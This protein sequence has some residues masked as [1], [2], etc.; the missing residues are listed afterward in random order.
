LG[1]IAPT[2]RMAP[3]GGLMMAL[4][5]Y[6]LLTPDDLT[7]GRA[8]AGTGALECD[9]GVVPIGGIEQKVAGAEQ[10]GAE[11]FLSPAGN[12]EA[13]RRAADDIEVVAIARFE[14]ALEYLDGLD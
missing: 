9:G 4:T 11:I 10:E 2:A 8:I 5:L 14:D 1:V 3:S 7:R 13:A 12:V 6:D